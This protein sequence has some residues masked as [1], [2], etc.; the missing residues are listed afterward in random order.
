MILFLS[1][2]LTVPNSGFCCPR[3]TSSVRTGSARSG[4]RREH[5]A[6]TDSQV[7]S[8]ENSSQAGAHLPVRLSV[9]ESTG[10]MDVH[11]LLVDQG[12][13]TLLRV[14]LGSVPEEPT[15]DGLLHSDCGLAAGNHIQLVSMGKTNQERTKT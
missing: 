11:H 3:N 2:G 13:V 7:P 6:P 12:P 14:L 8:T 5:R 4:G 15:A 10:R 9:E 1:E